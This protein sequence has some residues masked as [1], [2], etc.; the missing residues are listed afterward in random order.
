MSKL[1]YTLSSPQDRNELVTEIIDNSEPNQFNEKALEIMADYL[2]FCMEK[3][4]KK[5]KEI[6]TDNRKITVNKRETSLEGLTS[7]LENGE[8]GFYS[9]IANDKNIIFSPSISITKEDIET[10]PMLKQLRTEIDKVAKQSFTGKKAFLAKKM[11]IEMRQDQYIIKAAYRK[12]ITFVRALKGNAAPDWTDDIWVDENGNIKYSGN[13]TLYNPTHVSELLCNYSALK[14]NSYEDFNSDIRWLMEE[15]DN[16]IEACLKDK[17]PLYY[18][19]V[20]YKIDGMTNAEIRDKLE[21][22]YG[23]AHSLEYLSSLYRNKIPK[24]I[25]EYAKESWFNWYYTNIEKGEWKTCSKCG[26]TKLAHNIY[27]SK[28]KTA[29]SGFYSICKECRNA[30]TAD[31]ASK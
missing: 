8:D 16:T 23:I 5:E 1:D 7:K 25:S 21:Q 6:L 14:E 24:L 31:E 18:D 4:E 19:L 15:L 22:D 26:K 11:L 3:K 2:V 29:K 30:K 17:Y 10:I 28:N 9:L 20:I 12:P 13:V 27:F